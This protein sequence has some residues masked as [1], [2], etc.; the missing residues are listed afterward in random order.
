MATASNNEIA[1]GL[2]VKLKCSIV[3]GYV[4]VP[5]ALRTMLHSRFPLALLLCD[6]SFAF[7]LSESAG[8]YL[9][10]CDPLVLIDIATSTQTR[11]QPDDSQVG[12]Q[13]QSVRERRDVDEGKY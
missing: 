6:S 12:E 11:P 10:S 2:F 4:G 13:G 9:V 5:P 1:S 7:P 8:A 3:V